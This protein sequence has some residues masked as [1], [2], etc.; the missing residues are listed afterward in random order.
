M[1]IMVLELPR[2]PGGSFHDLRLVQ[3]KFLAYVLSFVII[4]IYWNNHHH[5]LQLVERIDGRVLWSNMFVLF[6]LSLV[7]F[8][9]AWLG[10]HASSRAPVVVYG[11]ILLGAGVGYFLLTLALLAL[12]DRSSA[13]AAAIGRDWK[14]KVSALAYVVALPLVVV[15]TWLPI[16]IYV[17]VAVVWFVPDRRIARVVKGGTV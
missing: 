2:P 13:L 14:G 15:G 1:T 11:A 12:H 7:P 10:E 4:A 5:L 17:A 6:W 8:A 16:A 3:P 9:T